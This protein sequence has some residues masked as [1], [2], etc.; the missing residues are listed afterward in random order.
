MTLV[1]KLTIPTLIGGIIA[2]A[3]AGLVTPQVHASSRQAHVIAQVT[4]VPDHRV[5]NVRSAPAP[6]AEMVGTI[7]RNSYI[8][9]ESCEAEWCLVERAGTKGWVSADYL[10]PHES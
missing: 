7:A 2:L 10:T 6:D 4:G 3:A 1:F 9:V 5:L 8:W